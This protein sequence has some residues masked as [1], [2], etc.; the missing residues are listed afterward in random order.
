[1]AIKPDGTPYDIAYSPFLL[2][3]DWMQ[4]ITGL[5]ETYVGVAG[6]ELSIHDPGGDLTKQLGIME[7]VIIKHPDAIILHPL[8]SAALGPLVDKAWDADIPTF[9]FDF[10][11]ESEHV[12]H[13]TTHDQ[14]EMGRMCGRYLVEEA[15]TTGK[16]IHCYAL[17]G[18]L[19]SEGCQRRHQGFHEVVDPCPLITVVEGPE[20]MGIREIVMNALMDYLPTHPECNAM[21]CHG[22]CT[23]PLVESLGML[24]RLYPVGHPDHFYHLTCDDGPGEIAAV[25]DGWCDGASSHSPHEEGDCMCKAMLANLCCGLEVPKLVMLDSYL[26]TAENVDN[27][28]YNAVIPWGDL[29]R[30]G[31]WRVLDLPSE[32]GIVTPTTDMKMPGY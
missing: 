30:E 13:A 25:R 28:R 2:S 9:N 24:D 5:I 19:G 14:L 21:F 18:V 4:A 11:I 7:D 12:V 23:E 1:V 31:P 32:F 17:F 3:I 6:G 8:D 22:T 29:T 20:Y 10:L 27:P 15:E 26:V 16:E